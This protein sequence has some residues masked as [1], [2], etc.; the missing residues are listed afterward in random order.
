MMNILYFEVLNTAT[1]SHM[2]LM[3]IWNVTNVTDELDF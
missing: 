2:K 1:K 3:N